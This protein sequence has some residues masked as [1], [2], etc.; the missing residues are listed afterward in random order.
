VLKPGCCFAGYEW[1]AT[2]QYDPN[3]EEHKKVR[4]RVCVCCVCIGGWDD[5]DRWWWSLSAE[6]GGPVGVES[7]PCPPAQD[8]MG[9]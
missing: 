8:D 3:N 6:A 4:A 2:D 9:A 5:D 1:C 7:T